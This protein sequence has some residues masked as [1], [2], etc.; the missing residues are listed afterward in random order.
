MATLAAPVAAPLEA[1][2]MAS[3]AR[4]EMAMMAVEADS[5]AATVATRVVQKVATAIEAT[6]ASEEATE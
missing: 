4:W 6:A 2:C 5:A 3:A 1:A